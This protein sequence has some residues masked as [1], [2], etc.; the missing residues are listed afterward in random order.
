MTKL[1]PK[2]A[3]I[4]YFA[5]LGKDLSNLGGRYSDCDLCAIPTFGWLCKKSPCMPD[6]RK[7]GCS[8]YFRPIEEVLEKSK[9][10][11]FDERT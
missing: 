4:G 9:K 7:D 6:W 3:P 2:E 5:V 8:V 11:A 10:A 1:N